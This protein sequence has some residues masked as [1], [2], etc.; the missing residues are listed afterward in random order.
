MHAAIGSYRRATLQGNG[1]FYRSMT[2]KQPI[3]LLKSLVSA[4]VDVLL[5]VSRAPV[6][7]SAPLLLKRKTGVMT[8]LHD[9]L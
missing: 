2:P 8:V 4:I 6:K 9:L 1:D 5:S 3:A 7:P